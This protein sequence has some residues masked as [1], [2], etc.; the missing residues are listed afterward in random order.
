VLPLRSAALAVLIASLASTAAAEPARIDQVSDRSFDE[1]LQQMEWALGGQA[2]TIVDR[3]DYRSLLGKEPESLRKSRL[4]L[5]LRRDWGAILVAND[6]SAALALPFHIHLYERPDG[7][8]VVSYY[9]PSSLFA[10]D[11]SPRL[12]ALGEEMDAAL[13]AAAQVACER[14]GQRD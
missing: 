12:Q 11:A 1:T 6:P 4:L 10:L 13:R 3:L 8:T 2:F 9:R 5:V 14:P 7:K